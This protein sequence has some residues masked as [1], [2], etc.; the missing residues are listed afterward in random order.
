MAQACGGSGQRACTIFERIP[1]CDPGL[2]EDGRATCWPCGAVG[3]AACPIT[4]QIPSCDAGGVENLLTGMCE[5]N[6]E[7][8][9]RRQ[10]EAV[11]NDV[12]PLV[13][14][15][16]EA[17]QCL[18]YLGL[19][20]RGLS[21]LQ[22]RD[23]VQAAGLL[24]GSGCLDRMKTIARDGGYQ[25]MTLGFGGGF[26]IGF[27][28]NSEFGVA[29]DLHDRFLPVGFV[30]NGYSMGLG[31]G[32]G[33]NLTVG[34]S[35]GDLYTVDGNEQGFTFTA[36]PAGVGIWYDYDGTYSGASFSG[37]YGLGL[38]AG[39]LNRVH[40]ALFAEITPVAAAAP[41]SEAPASSGSAPA[42]YPYGNHASG[43]CLD[44]AE[45]RPGG[46]VVI[47]DCN[48]LNIAFFQA[49]QVFDT[50]IQNSQSGMCLDVAE[51]RDG[52]RVVLDQCGDAN[53]R[54]FQ[55]WYSLDGNRIVNNASGLCLDVSQNVSGGQVVI[56]HCGGA[57]ERPF[58]QW[59]PH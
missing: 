26:S 29:I 22:A 7:D 37:S 1:S 25:T 40:T 6:Q 53:Q 31:I 55:V 14:I 4:V 56:A 59:S 2:F 35:H 32:A 44:L 30:T 17:N 51:N 38:E 18:S 48:A 24:M 33:L 34:L 27:G 15:Y 21:A 11:L 52:G 39:V 20:E 13:E 54:P 3:E 45:N 8:H 58:Q 41:V 47:A 36:G 42:G 12:R 46:N 43:R 57:G 10:A 19:L 5:F 9:L 49:W 50:R 23:A 16:M 28:A